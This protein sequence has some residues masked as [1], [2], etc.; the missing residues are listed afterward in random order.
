MEKAFVVEP[1]KEYDVKIK[2]KDLVLITDL[3][4]QKPYFQV[5]SIIES[6][7]EQVKLTE[8]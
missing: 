8:K 7:L 4:E 6:I 1:E 3:L 2:G 5:K